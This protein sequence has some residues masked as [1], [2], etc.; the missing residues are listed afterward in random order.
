[1]ESIRLMS[2]ADPLYES[3]RAIYDISFPIYEQRTV[4]Q[5]EYAFSFSCYHLDTY[6]NDGKLIG[7][8]AY[9]EFDS[10]LYIE[11]FAIHPDERG[12]GTGKS[13]LEH[14][15]QTHSK[16]ILLEIDPVQDEISARRL[17]FYSSIGFL[18]NPHQHVHPAYRE[19]FEGHRLTVLTTERVITPDEY[20]VF[21]H[22]LSHTVMN[23]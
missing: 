3:F 6:V 11:H 13:I 10:Y 8:I 7:F 17:R 5:Q 19:G 21:A 1:M 9:W 16:Y 22:D 15:I 23:R 12:K 2:T 18:E 4:E 20:E 14:L